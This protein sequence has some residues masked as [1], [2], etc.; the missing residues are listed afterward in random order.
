MISWNKKFVN[1]K[2]VIWAKHFKT[3]A[4]AAIF[5]SSLKFLDK[6]KSSIKSDMSV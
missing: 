4:D 1:V 2:M 5:H 6:V 3:L